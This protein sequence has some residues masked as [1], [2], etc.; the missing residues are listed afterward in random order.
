MFVPY[1]PFIQLFFL[2]VFL[3]KIFFFIWLI[4][5]CIILDY[6]VT[7]FLFEDH[8]ILSLPSLIFSF[9]YN[10]KAINEIQEYANPHKFAPIENSWSIKF[11]KKKKGNM[12]VNHTMKMESAGGENLYFNF[13]W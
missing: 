11:Q 13:E 3:P 6:P 8:F 12:L 7:F 9:H 4:L 1:G 2:Q 5:S 10:I